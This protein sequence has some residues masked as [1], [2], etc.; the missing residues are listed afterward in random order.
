MEP[1]DSTEIPHRRRLD[2]VASFAGRGD[3]LGIARAVWAA[4][5]VP[6]EAWW[7]VTPGEEPHLLLALGTNPPWWA[8]SSRG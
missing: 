4:T 8:M 2:R 1:G 7:V 5:G 6:V 3:P